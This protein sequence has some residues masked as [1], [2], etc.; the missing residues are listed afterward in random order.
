MN[1]TS[2]RAGVYTS[3]QVSNVS[4]STLSRGVVGAAARASTGSP[5]TVY[6]ISSAADAKRIFGSCNLTRLIQAALNNGAATVAAVPIFS[7]TTPS[8]SM[9][10]TAFARLAKRE[11]VQ[12]IICDSRTGSVHA[13]M[14]T[15]ITD[16]DNTEPFKI[17]VVEISG[18]VSSTVS[19]A[20]D[21]DCER[22]IMVA[23]NAAED[24][25]LMLD[26]PILS[27]SLAGAI[28][29]EADP[30]RP[31]NGA[32]LVGIDYLTMPLSEGEIN[33]LV[34][35][36]VCPVEMSGGKVRVI[37]GV[38]TRTTDGNGASD[39][40]W[41]ELTTV[42]IV[43]NVVPEVRNTLRAMFQRAKNTAQTRDAIRTQ[44][45]VVLEK[46]IAAEIIDS[47]GNVSVTRDA[48]DPT[49]CNVSFEFAVAHG[50]N[51]IVLTANIT[52]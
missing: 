46:K 12:V 43:D 28:V 41:H 23:P 38:T 44:V 32:E 14:K 4:Y 33:S 7:S 29:S 16:S 21:L 8:D 40:T 9:Y 35:G 6:E 11:D 27:A 25:S 26:I 10:A 31:I 18:S 24:S 45:V 1:V 13:A 22:M 42:R 20:A 48:S 5:A 51:K 50:L 49:I 3:Y 36:G 15:A 47:Y 37:R 17:G 52:V 39:P 2:E 19:A 34:R 30:A